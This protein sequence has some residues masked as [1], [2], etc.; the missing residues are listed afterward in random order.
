[1]IYI[2]PDLINLF[3][4]GFIFVYTFD[5]LN[6]KKRD[7]SLI[8]IWSLFVSFLVQSFY[9]ILH[10]FILVDIQFNIPAKAIIYSITGLLLALLLTYIKNSKIF[11]RLLRKLNHK[12]INDDIFDDIIDYDKIT[13]MQVYIKSSDIYYI[14][15]F[16]FREENGLNSWISLIYYV[17]VDRKTN[18]VL[19]D[20]EEAK[21][22]S[23]VAIK[24]CDVERIEIIYS[25]DSEVWKRL[26]E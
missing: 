14:G 24:L 5:W 11:I 19:F 4:S 2:I 3:L 9:S 21:H 17:C 16:S 7:I 23:S 26:T 6:G 10:G 12:S 13:M 25:E 18:E 20:P 8:T 1:M 22:D 15:R